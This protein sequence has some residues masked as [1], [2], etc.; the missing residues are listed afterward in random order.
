MILECLSSSC[1]VVTQ[2]DEAAGLVSWGPLLN[3]NVLSTYIN[4][5]G[6]LTQ[7][8]NVTEQFARASAHATLRD[9][10]PP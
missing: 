3:Q 1:D 7:P 2:R 9:H 6:A 4:R 5:Q 10:Q 8:R